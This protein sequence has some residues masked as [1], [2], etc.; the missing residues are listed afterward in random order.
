[1][2]VGAGPAGLALALHLA[3]AGGRVVVLE[4]G[5][6]RPE[7]GVD[8]AAALNDGVVVGDRFDSLVSGRARGLGGTAALWHGQCMRLHE[9]DLRPRAWIPH[10]G[11][12][13]AAGDL[14]SAYARAEQWLGVSGRGYGPERWAEHPEAA[15]PAWDSGRLL[16]D[17]TE[18]THRPDVAKQHRNRL[19]GTA[20]VTVALHATVTR[21]LSARGS[22]LGVEVA[23]SSG[24]V[25][26]LPASRVV[27]AASA[28]ENARILQ[29][30]DPDGV[31]LGFG[32]TWTGRFL[33]T[34]PVVD[35]AVIRP[36]SGSLLQNAYLAFASHRRRLFPKL[37]LAPEA[38]EAHGLVDACAVFAYDY[39]SE[40]LAAA[41]RVLTAARS[42]RV[43]ADLRRDLRAMVTHA[44]PVLRDGYRH[45][46][47]G[48]GTAQAPAQVRLELWLEQAPDPDNRVVLDTSTDSV[49]LHRPRVEWRVG[50]HELRTSRQMT[51]WISADVERLGLGSV[52]HLPTMDDDAAWRA[53]A[54]DAAHASGTTRMS[55]DAGLG[56]VDP[57]LQVHGVQGLYV[58]GASVFPTAGY[59]NPTLTVVALAVRL[60]RHLMGG[61]AT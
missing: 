45:L 39:E 37:R 32:R 20:G 52:E 13:E 58:L 30:S 7:T 3:D 51:E 24:T 19:R 31:G 44:G 56:V 15:P 49:G 22:V 47:R 60:A 5:G 28:I 41:R 16:D 36:G 59:A 50:E 4:S 35:M 61:R 8:G 9:V 17:F 21:V 14:T 10:S 23:D 55:T 25:T 33:Q 38:Q 18:Y 57:D 54:R 40:H 6:S 26:K 48:L 27:L 46:A 11:W 42:R 29:L 53:A 12:P 34:H 1:V 2:V 43:P